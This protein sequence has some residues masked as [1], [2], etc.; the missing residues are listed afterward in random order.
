MSYLVS[1]KVRGKRLSPRCGDEHREVYGEI[2]VL[3]EIGSLVPETN[4]K[5]SLNML[6][7]DLHDC[8]T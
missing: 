4:E 6:T 5:F 8:S 3:A 2:S 7:F 1:L